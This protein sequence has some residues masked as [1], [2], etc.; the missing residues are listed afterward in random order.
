MKNLKIN[1][2]LFLAILSISSCSKD[3]DGIVAPPVN[4]EE[5]I[6][7]VTAVFTPQA[8]GTAITLRSRDLDGG[9]GPA[10]PVYAVSGPFAQSTTYNGVVTVLNESVSPAKDITL[11][12]IEEATD[13]QLFYQKTGT[14]PNFVYA[15]GNDNLDANGKPLGIKTTFTTTTAATGSL[16][17]IL[18]HLP[19]KSASGVAGGD[20]TNAGGTSDFEVLF[21]GIAVQ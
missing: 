20:I 4:E 17:I 7:T 14:L 11:E 2:L 16:T 13:H 12:I 15:T 18:R 9:D 8:G 3:D 1:V 10:L 21:T 5:V 19:N 6:T